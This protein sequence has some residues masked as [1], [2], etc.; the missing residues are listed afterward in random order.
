MRSSILGFCLIASL[1][2]VKAL[3]IH[4]APFI[5]APTNFNSFEALGPVTAAN[6]V[7]SHTED[8]IAVQYIGG[9]VGGGIVSQL[10]WAPAISGAYSWYPGV[11]GLG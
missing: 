4:S 5:T 11:W 6:G 9:I 10:S 8:S 3:T 1:S 2:P 7:T